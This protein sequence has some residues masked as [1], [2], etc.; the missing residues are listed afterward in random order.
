MEVVN[1]T[2]LDYH[3]EATNHL[4]AQGMRSFAVAQDDKN[5]EFRKAIGEM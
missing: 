1:C 5:E 3:A 2:V 4:A